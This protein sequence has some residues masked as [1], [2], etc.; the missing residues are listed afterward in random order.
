MEIKREREKEVNKLRAIA[1]QIGEKG[2]KKIVLAPYY[3]F[4]S[5]ALEEVQHYK[6]AR[7]INDPVGMKEELTLI[8]PETIFDTTRYVCEGIGNV[9]AGIYNLLTY[10]PAKI[11]AK[12]AGKK[13]AS[14]LKLPDYNKRVGPI[15]QLTDGGLIN[16][17]DVPC[18]ALECFVSFNGVRED[19]R[20]KRTIKVF[21]DLVDNVKKATEI[22]FA[23][24]F[25]TARNLLLGSYW[26]I[27]KIIGGTLFKDEVEDHDDSQDY[28]EFEFERMN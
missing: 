11:I 26:G 8:I 20:N 24:S 10:Y 22:V 14:F 2:I 13:D 12:T 15:W 21:S 7:D 18:K 27:K 23:G 9:A 25:D 3:G 6:R 19:V 16:L 17:L 1:R 28:R 5:G 4:V